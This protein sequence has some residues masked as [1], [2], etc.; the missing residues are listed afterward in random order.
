MTER[1]NPGEDKAWELLIAMRPGDVC[2]AAG[3]T[4]DERAQHYVVPS[5]G[6]KFLVSPSDRTVVSE[7][8]AGLI[9]LSKVA[10]F[11]RLSILWYLVSARDVAC[12]GRPVKLEGITGGEIFTKGSHVLPLDGLAKK[13]G[14][15][16][17]AFVA[18]GR[19]LGGEPVPQT[20]A[21]VRLLPFPRIPVTITLWTADD[22]FP[23][24]ADMLF[25]SSCSLHL[26]MDILWSVAMFCALMMLQG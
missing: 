21:A 25:D 16:A 14:S 12:T 5:L 17:A 19:Q 20:D 11:F 26:P 2:R 22:E 13:Y 15:D 7:S 23:A 3:V 18:R 1:S 10:Y 24:R 9:L 8:E 4:Y 6:M